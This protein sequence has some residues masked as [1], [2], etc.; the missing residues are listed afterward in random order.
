MSTN[1]NYDLNYE[2]FFMILDKYRKE[3]NIFFCS[4][5][6][7]KDFCNVIDDEMK[8][9]DTWMEYWRNNYG[10]DRFKATP[11]INNKCWFLLID[12]CNSR[13]DHNKTS[14]QSDEEFEEFLDTIRERLL[15]IWSDTARAVLDEIISD[16][17]YY[18]MPDFSSKEEVRK[19]MGLIAIT[20]M[21]NFDPKSYYE[22]STKPEL[23]RV[24]AYS[25]S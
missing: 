6:M 3:F 11:E 22:E 10:G 13:I 16:A 21:M 23:E 7:I 4:E 25:K 15:D 24:Y 2:K 20:I 9:K 12:S 5:E 19:Y 14:W 18:Y 17:V 1:S 8:D